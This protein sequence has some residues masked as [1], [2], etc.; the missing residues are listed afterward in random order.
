MAASG[1]CDGWSLLRN[2]L[3][4]LDLLFGAQIGELHLSLLD[5]STLSLFKLLQIGLMHLRSTLCHS[6]LIF[7]GADCLLRLLIL[8]RMRAFA[9]PAI[10]GFLQIR[11]SEFALSRLLVIGILICL[12]TVKVT[13][14][15]T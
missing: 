8:V 3:M 1:T 15:C 10:N 6:R 11:I 9:S 14:K 2:V 4:S 7:V 13:C 12:L 5:I